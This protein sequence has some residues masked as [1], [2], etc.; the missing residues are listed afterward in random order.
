MHSASFA[1]SSTV[2]DRV[3]IEISNLPA[4]VSLHITRGITSPSRR[5]RGLPN[6]GSNIP[7]RTRV[8]SFFEAGSLELIA[9]PTITA[10]PPIAPSAIAAA[11]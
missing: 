10:M 7:A 8:R 2:E 3:E 1:T 9:I 5:C 6:R 4:S 11:T